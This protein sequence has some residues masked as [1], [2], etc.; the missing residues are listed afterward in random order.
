MDI[1]CGKPK[2]SGK[3]AALDMEAKLMKKIEEKA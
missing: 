2:I 3:D 1:I